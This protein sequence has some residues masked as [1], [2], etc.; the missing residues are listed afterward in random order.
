MKTTETIT[1]AEYREMMAK[2]PHTPK[3][4]G[5]GEKAKAEI[6]LILKLLGVEFEKDE[7]FHP[8]RKWR[9][10]WKLTKYKIAIEYEGLFSDKSRH[11]NV[12][13]YSNDAEKYNQAQLLG[14]KVLR[15]TALNYKQVATDLRKELNL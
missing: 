15:Y 6:D 4:K 11:T 8:D 9:F 3:T 5:N 14:W 2:K 7:T 12:K 13:G 10:D 1:A